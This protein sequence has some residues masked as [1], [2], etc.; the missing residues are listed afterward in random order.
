MHKYIFGLTGTHC[1]VTLKFWTTKC[2]GQ[3]VCG[4]CAE[5]QNT[6]ANLFQGQLLFRLKDLVR[7]PQCSVRTK[8]CHKG[9]VEK[10]ARA[11]SINWVENP[12]TSSF[13]QCQ[14]YLWLKKAITMSQQ[15][16][17]FTARSKHLICDWVEL[18]SSHFAVFL[19]FCLSILQSVISPTSS[20]VLGRKT[21]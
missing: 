16:E 15:A 1:W 11:K 12:H 10:T 4:T 2:S 17:R 18:L 7:T 13:R 8:K 3:N 6:P 5:E 9:R 19:V 21:R 20:S 14:L